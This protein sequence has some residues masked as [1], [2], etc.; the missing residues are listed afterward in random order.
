MGKVREEA[1][2]ED[3]DTDEMSSELHIA[4]EER[5]DGLISFQLTLVALRAAVG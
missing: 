1:E 4:L 2:E 5:M 3:E